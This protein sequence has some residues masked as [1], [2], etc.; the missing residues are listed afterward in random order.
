M[1]HSGN[2]V[3]LCINFEL[4]I[5]GCKTQDWMDSF[6]FTY[7]PAHTNLTLPTANFLRNSH[8]KLVL[9]ETRRIVCGIVKP[10]L[11]FLL[12]RAV[13]WPDGSAIK[14]DHF[15]SRNN[16][17]HVARERRNLILIGFFK[18]N[19]SPFSEPSK[20]EPM[21]ALFAAANYH[22]A[23]RWMPIFHHTKWIWNLPKITS[24]G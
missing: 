18:T 16:H 3:C 20:R 7:K 23:M 2:C 22:C 21:I 14:Q 15:N 4:T 5:D 17:T 13:N 8:E 10:S 11:L 9:L 12:L 19:I 6:I 24:H 1:S